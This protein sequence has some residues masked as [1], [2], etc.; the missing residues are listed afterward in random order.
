[1]KGILV[2]GVSGVLLVWWWR[3]RGDD[4]DGVELFATKHKVLSSGG[5]GYEQSELGSR[6]NG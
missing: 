5:E 3:G 4:P 1:M 6:V 2:S